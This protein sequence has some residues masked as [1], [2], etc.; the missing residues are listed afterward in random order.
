MG[1]TG[2]DIIYDF[3]DD[4]LASIM[5]GAY[6]VSYFMLWSAFFF[7][8]S[9]LSLVSDGATLFFALFTLVICYC[10]GTIFRRSDMKK[11]DKKSAYSIYK[12]KAQDQST[13]FH[14][15]AEGMHGAMEKLKEEYKESDYE[16]SLDTLYKKMYKKTKDGKLAKLRFRLT[17]RWTGAYGQ[18]YRY[19]RT[20]QKEIDKE[21]Q[22]DQ[23]DPL[24]KLCDKL[25]LMLFP[26][27]DYPYV[28]LKNYLSE[29]NLPISKYAEWNEGTRSKM[30]TNTY[31]V[32]IAAKAPHMM[33]IINKNE[34]HI[35]FM[36]SM[37]Y[38]SDSLLYCAA[39]IGIVSVV[40]WGVL[41]DTAVEGN[42]QALFSRENLS[43]VVV[44]SLLYV[45]VSLFVK[46]SVKKIIHYQRVR[47][48]VFLLTSY[49]EVEELRKTKTGENM[50]P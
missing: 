23:E 19:Y 38:A 10:L 15:F 26:Q 44:I 14:A 1:H 16:S 20:L 12:A 35:R 6:F 28:K 27:I 43:I 9:L 42:L 5:P 39:V 3:L 49:A 18:L 40:L 22:K 4:I 45:A 37:W 36:N 29:R 31:K 50:K 24:C 46:H 2:W 11:I 41:P 48:L 17:R 8:K 47:E 32:E 21:K 13:T 7:R 30:K 33:S 34:A 25:K